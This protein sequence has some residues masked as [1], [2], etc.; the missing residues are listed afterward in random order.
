MIYDKL[1]AKI[2]LISETYTNVNT[3]LTYNQLMANYYRQTS[4]ITS[5]VEERIATLW[6][7]NSVST[8]PML[9]LQLLLKK[10]LL[11]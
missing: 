6:P 9:L 5:L 11:L 3:A 7:S 10:T 4:V 8:T 1:N 2:G